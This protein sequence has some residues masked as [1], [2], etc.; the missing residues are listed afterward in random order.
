MSK[1]QSISFLLSQVRASGV[2]VA[3]GTV[4]AFQAGSTTVRK[5]IW[6]DRDKA[7]EAAN[8]YQ[9][10]ANGTAHLFGDGLYRIVIKDASGA[11]KYDRD[12]LSFRDASSNVYDVADYAS[13]AAAVASIGSTPATLQ[14]ASDVTVSANLVIPSTLEL[15]PLNKAKINH[16]TYT[17]SYAGSTARWP[18]AQIFNGTGAVYFDNG[19]ASEVY[20]EWFYSGTGS[21][22]TAINAAI[23]SLSFMEIDSGIFPHP[24]QLSRG[25]GGGTVK[26]SIYPYATTDSIQMH[27]SVTLEGAGPNSSI[28]MYSGSGK[29]ILMGSGIT[30][31]GG[32]N[33]W[34]TKW[35]AV[36][37]LGIYGNSNATDAIFVNGCVHYEIKDV[38]IDKF[39]RATSITYTSVPWS[40]AGFAAGTINLPGASGIHLFDF[41]IFGKIDHVL[42]RRCYY[43]LKATSI[44]PV[45]SAQAFNACQITGRSEFT[46]NQY[47][48]VIGT[49]GAAGAAVVSL[50]ATIDGSTT[51]QGNAL[52]G[53]WIAEGR[54]VNVENTYY[55]SNS[56][57]DVRLGDTV[58]PT[59]AAGCNVTNNYFNTATYAVDVQNGTHGIITGNNFD[60]QGQTNIVNLAA[61][62]GT[63]R[64]A[65]M[66]V[67][68]N[69]F[70][71][72]PVP[73]VVNIGFQCIVHNLAELVIAP[74]LLNS[75]A[76]VGGAQQTAGYYRDSDGYINLQGYLQ[77][78][79]NNTIIFSI[80]ANISFVGKTEV[81]IGWDGSVGQ[82]T[83][84]VTQGGSTTDVKAKVVGGGG[85]VSLAGIK[86]KAY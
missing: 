38:L 53:L 49:Y 8:P 7:I 76:N 69:R 16:A 52:G 42:V 33:G 54:S 55:E 79:A 86:F 24:D 71:G 15:M 81:F 20:P 17:I 48:A 47:G 41:T 11:V 4:D 25:A 64:A 74:T 60:G 78:G 57:F 66:R 45:A 40:G 83:V 59:P 32:T 36:R 31:D 5:T 13:L 22:H 28:I 3:G 18:L 61:T 73:G 63:I 72:A 39:D 23:N 1:A 62:S 44:S 26:L 9:L 14:F 29:A 65:Y 70:N 82:T 43:G 77:G 35:V 34:F 68:D 50:N 67:F 37:N 21:W 19:S 75:W 46:L 56:N 30:G 85:K 80:P 51:F 84:E 2:V 58:N 12:G 27:S 6:Q 10:D